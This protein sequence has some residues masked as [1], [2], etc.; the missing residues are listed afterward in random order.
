MLL[1]LIMEVQPQ[2]I[3]CNVSRFT[4]LLM[5]I[6]MFKTTHT[7]NGCIAVINDWLP[8]LWRKLK[9]RSNTL[10]VPSSGK[11]VSKAFLGYRTR[12]N[13]MSREAISH[14]PYHLEFTCQR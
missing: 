13:S 1:G 12:R 3:S 7:G 4:I 8:Y 10:H 6:G 5:A 11:A 2:I 9:R 14:E